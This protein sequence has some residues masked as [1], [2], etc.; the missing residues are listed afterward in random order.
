MLNRPFFLSVTTIRKM[1]FLRK[2]TLKTGPLDSIIDL[3][4]PLAGF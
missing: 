1:W 3:E 4:G 2:I